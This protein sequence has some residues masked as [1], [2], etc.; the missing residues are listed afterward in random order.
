MRERVEGVTATL[1]GLELTGIKWMV[2]LPGGNFGLVPVIVTVSALGITAGAVYTP[3]AVMEP[4]AGLKVQVELMGA[5]TQFKRE[6]VWLCEALRFAVAGETVGGG[7]RVRAA[8][9][10]ALGLAALS[11]V[12][13]MLWTADTVA[14]A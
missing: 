1:T 5:P 10:R 12:T 13:V 11:A 2:A 3:A 14:G 6:N 4:M 8:V 7:T 9:A